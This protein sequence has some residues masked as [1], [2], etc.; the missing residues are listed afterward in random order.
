[1]SKILTTILLSAIILI[2][3]VSTPVF[4]A[5]VLNSDNGH[6]YEFVDSSDITWTGA[7]TAAEALTH[8]GIRGHLVTITSQSE[9]E[10][11]AGLVSDSSHSWIGLSDVD[12]EGVYKWVNG[13][14][15][16]YSNWHTSQPDNSNNQDY[17]EFWGHND[18]W[19]DNV[20][21][22]SYITGYIVEY[23]I[24]PPVKNPANGHYY[25]LANNAGITWTD[26]KTAAEALTLN[27]TSGYLVTITDSS[28]N[29]FVAGLV[30][31]DAIAWIGLTDRNTEGAYKWITGEPFRYS[32]W[33][34]GQPDN[35]GNTDYVEFYGNDDKWNDNFNDIGHTTGYI[36][37]Y[38]IPYT[39]PVYNPANGHYYQLA[40]NAG[41][42]WTDAKIMA[43]DYVH[44]GIHGHLV[45]ITSQSE[46]DFVAG[47]VP[48][49]F[50]AWIGLTD[51]RNEGV[52]KWVTGE[53]FS[54]SNW[55]TGQPDNSNNEDYVQF[56]GLNDKWNDISNDYDYSN[57]YIIEYSL[58]PPVYNPATD[59]YYEYIN[60]P[61]VTWT[62]AERMA[63]AFT[64]ND[65][66]GTLVT[67]TSASEN[68]F[69]SGLLSNNTRA[70]IG[71]FDKNT[72]GF[73]KWLTGEPFIYSNWDTS[74]PDNN[75]NEDYVEFL[76]SNNKWHD[77]TNDNGHTTGFVI[78]YQRQYTPPMQNP[79]N[80]H[81]YEYIHKSSS[82]WTD[83]K[84]AAESSRF[85]GAYGNLV[86]IGNES[87]NDFVAGLVPDDARAWIGLT[88]VD[89]Q[90]A[91]KWISDEPFS[92]SNWDTS[93]PPNDDGQDYVDINGLNGKWDDNFDRNA[94][95]N[96]YVIEYDRQH[97]PPVYNPENGHYYKLGNGFGY[98][99][100][101]ANAAAKSQVF[102]GTGSHLVTITSQSENDFVANLIPDYATVWIGLTD[103][104]TE[105][106]YTWVTEELLIDSGWSNIEPFDY[107]NWDTSQPDNANNEDYVEFNGNNDKWNDNRNAHANGYVI[108][109]TPKI[110]TKNPE[111]GHYYEWIFYPGVSSNEA[112]DIA[113]SS[114]LNG[115]S[116]YL[117]TIT[118]QSEND[119]V[120]ELIPQGGHNTGFVIEYGPRVTTPDYNQANGHYYEYIVSNDISW[121]EANTTA[122]LSEF[123]GTSGTLVT[124]TDSSENDFV[125]GL[126]PDDTTVWIGSTDV[127]SAG[128]YK[129][130]TGEPFIY[131]NWSTGQPSAGTDDDFVGFYGNNDK[132]FSS[133]HWNYLIDGYIIEYSP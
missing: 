44:N 3:M 117:A 42:T 66:N 102:E 124:I 92:Y 21:S 2:F 101:G 107:S 53:T 69:V 39:P 104:T 7:K 28:E 109:F 122:K 33:D 36:I 90:G 18:K 45:S 80:G 128:D 50:R 19:Y 73:Y 119:F 85:Y 91:Y 24:S 86:T 56:Y 96:G 13:E 57:G 48:S 99:W 81:Y 34:T 111:N 15:F 133:Y 41:I 106:D 76:G 89:T 120:D 114:E 125:T 14:S 105:G 72:E 63:K 11:V 108:E 112:K 118:S 132:W 103:V 17:V 51:S 22:D 70:W 47:L 20:N 123:N 38:S 82:K 61:G 64:H 55:N 74:Q 4:A 87:E 127:Q 93:Q 54:Y 60:N 116:G 67:I 84:I 113:E 78:E 110:P 27:G 1:M 59:H 83:A 37:E 58:P 79:A 129:W 23:S 46:N 121:R 5:P 12:T 35:A 98:S 75:S 126:V 131:S 26:A 95:T 29:D 49:D 77:N 88:D 6:Y 97:T 52:Y 71:L 9:N 62:D 65:I 40:N 100:T 16:S 94:H 30:P 115:M 68:D 32:N 25:Q 10:F 43:E 31:D 8:N 130:V